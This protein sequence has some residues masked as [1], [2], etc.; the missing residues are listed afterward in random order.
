MRRPLRVAAALATLAAAAGVLATGAAAV[1]PQD[2]VWGAS[3]TSHHAT[4]HPN[5]IVWGDTVHIVQA[6]TVHNR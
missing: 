1:H 4:V 3:P 6:G 5:D 2:V